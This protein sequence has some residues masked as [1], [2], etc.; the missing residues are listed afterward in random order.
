[1]ALPTQS[2]TR[3]YQ[4]AHGLGSD[5]FDQAEALSLDK[6]GNLYVT[7]TF[8]DT[9]DLEPGSG[10]TRLGSPSSNIRSSLFLQKLDTAG[11]L[12]WARAILSE[13]S[14]RVNDLLTDGSGNIK[15]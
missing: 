2:Q 11:N 6:K 1:M 13:G 3:Y 10:R 4:W 7:G 15:G 12:K 5:G 8:S 9:I 14:I